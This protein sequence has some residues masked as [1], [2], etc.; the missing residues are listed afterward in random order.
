MK[1]TIPQE[2][3]GVTAE[4]A[5][6]LAEAKKTQNPAPVTPASPLTVQANVNGADYIQVPQFNTLIGKRE[7]LKGKNW[8][9]T[10]YE[11]ADK[12]LYMPNPA[13]FMSHF[14]N[15]KSASEGQNIL[16][17]GN[18]SPISRDE[19]REQWN[20][21]SST[22]RS[23]FNG[24]ICW[25]WLDALFKKGT[26]GKLNMVTENRA[27]RDSSG[28]WN[29]PTG[30]VVTL[31]SYFEKSGAWVDLSFNK[32]G[33]AEKASSHNNYVQGANIY[34]WQ[35]IENRVARFVANSDWAYLSCDWDPS[36]TDSYLG[37]FP[38]AEGT[39]APKK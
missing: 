27:V 32:Q 17:D 22:D 30:K 2:F 7:I 10:H 37:V 29:L 38:C 21:L 28:I 33:L 1:Y 4:E 14:M 18:R 3:M 15:V 23:P 13:I 39:V 9:S 25:T 12:G 8:V 5:L 19:S 34:F 16:Y 36:L 20:Y 26:T 6:R 11:L 24:Q 35:P 31:D